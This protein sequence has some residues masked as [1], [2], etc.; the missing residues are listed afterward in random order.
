MKPDVTASCIIFAVLVSGCVSHHE[1]HEKLVEPSERDGKGTAVITPSTPVRI[2][3][4]GTWRFDIVAGEGGIPSGGGIVLQVSPWWGW[5]PPQSEIAAAPGFCTVR[6]TAGNV[7][8]STGGDPSRYYFL[9]EISRGNLDRGDTVMIVYGDTQSGLNPG[10]AAV[11]DRYAE[12]F[13]EFLIKTDG[14]GDGVFGEIEDQPGL[15]ILPREASELWV[16]APSLVRPGEPF[17]VSVSALDIAGDLALDYAGT[18]AVRTSPGISV[19]TV[20][21]V[22]SQHRGARRFTAVCEQPGIHSVGVNDPR[23]GFHVES[24]PFLCGDGTLFSRVYWGDIHGHTSLSDGTGDPRDYYRYARDGAGLDVAAITDH[25]ALGFRPLKGESWR[26]IRDAAEAFME[27]GRF[28]TILG[29][30]W[31]SWTYGHRNVYFPGMEGE[32]LSPYDSGADTPD[33]LFSL[34]EK[35]NPLTI[36]HHVAGG[37]VA[38]DWAHTP[39]H[40]I[41]RLSEVFSVHGNCEYEGCPGMIYHAESGHFI[42]DALA[43]GRRLGLLASGDGHVGHPGRWIPSYEQGLV[44]FLADELTREAIWESLWE[45]RVYGTSGARILI[46]FTIN[47]YPVG[48]EIP[49]RHADSPRRCIVHIFGTD[50]VSTIELIKNNIVIATVFGNSILE[51]LEYTDDDPART[52]DYYY[53]RITQRDGHQ[54]WAGPI[55]LGEE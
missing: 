48:S 11:A 23:R 17:E 51:S 34:L 8:F 32:P 2:G 12:R 5:S 39:R 45:R 7:E 4:R 24:N 1:E 44:G 46:T 38:V 10:A 9:V 6:S 41:E 52:G 54:A 49:E 29:Y 42:Q 14:D 28:V 33:G 50:T 40:P 25:A 36:P 37:P 31:T 35:W 3:E 53:T 19:P 30:E 22:G 15:M 18:L 47:D 43:E 20:M 21:V 26:L 13:Q 55:W 27:P 16:N